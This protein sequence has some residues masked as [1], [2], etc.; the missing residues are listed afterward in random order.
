MRELGPQRKR[1]VVLF[2]VV[3]CMAGG[4]VLLKGH[5]GV[6]AGWIA[7]QLVLLVVGVVQLAKL[8]RQG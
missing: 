5:P 8:K 3:A 6:L 2:A 7:M 4:P 1:V